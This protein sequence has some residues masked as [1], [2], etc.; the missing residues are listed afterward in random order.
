MDNPAVEAARPVDESVLPNLL[1]IQTDEHNF[2]TLGC[3][4]KLLAAEEAFVWGRRAIVTTPNIDSIAS[5]GAICTSFY[6]ASP[7]CSPSRASLLTGLYPHN[8]GV[9]TNNMELKHGVPTLATVL[10]DAGYRTGY[11][12][13]WHL[14]GVGKP[15]WA[16]KRK[17]GFVDNRYM[18][19][20]GHWKQ[21]EIT[22]NG[23]RVK[24]MDK[25]GRP[26]YAV[27]G[28]DEESFSTDWLTDRALEFI[29]NPSDKPF[30]YFLSLPDPHGPNTA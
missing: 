8:T 22:P 21:F 1:I 20:R 10:S 30:F 28:A 24:A 15:Q 14:D 27:G 6:A 11:A 18:F 9:P 3:Y 5:A 12:G 4:R 29:A 23:P 2:R 17:F 25:K 13:K 26:S 19:N 7:V 16:P